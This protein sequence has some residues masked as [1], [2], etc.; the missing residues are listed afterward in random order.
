MSGTDTSFDCRAPGNLESLVAGLASDAPCVGEV[1][2][3]GAARGSVN[4]SMKSGARDGI[5]ALI[6]R[7]PPK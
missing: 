4:L 2:V 5:S 3:G 1:G 7:V 6:A